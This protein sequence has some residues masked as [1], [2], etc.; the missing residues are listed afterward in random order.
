MYI[1]PGVTT[2]KAVAS[3]SI[4]NLINSFHFNVKMPTDFITSCYVLGYGQ[5]S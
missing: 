2:K 5:S 1:L 3:L 4:Y